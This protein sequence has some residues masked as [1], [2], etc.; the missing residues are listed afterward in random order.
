[1]FIRWARGRQMILIATLMCL[2]LTVTAMAAQRTKLTFATW[3]YREYWDAWKQAAAGFEVA[4]PDVE[5]ELVEVPAMGNGYMEWMAVRA[6]ADLMPD[7]FKVWSAL[8]SDFYRS[9]LALD[10]SNHLTRDQA[11]VRNSYF[12]PPDTFAGRPYAVIDIM[13][14][15]I[16]VYDPDQYDKV[17]MVQPVQLYLQK[18]WDFAMW[19]NYVRKTTVREADGRATQ[20]GLIHYGA[21]YLVISRLL[22]AFGASWMSADGKEPVFDRPEGLAAISWWANRF[23]EDG[24]VGPWETGYQTIWDTRCAPMLV[25]W[26]VPKLGQKVEGT[27]SAY[28]DYVPFPVGPVAE[29]TTNDPEPWAI[30]AQTKYPDLAWELVKHLTTAAIDE[31]FVQRGVMPNYRPALRKLQ[32]VAAHTTLGANGLG[33]A[34]QKAIPAESYPHYGQISAV[35]N[36]LVNDTARGQVGVQAAVEDAARQVR[37]IAQ[38]AK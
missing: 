22:G 21:E 29:V 3:G 10:L 26:G 8:R 20:A 12:A 32:P 16:L 35:L 28:R 23:L 17:G 13:Y 5:V 30:A 34:M 33:E 38:G 37:S 25:S 2:S 15:H 1:M 11:F 31:V 6:A 4:H 14:P 18:Q 27:V 9:G 36:K 7:V 19:E 24:W